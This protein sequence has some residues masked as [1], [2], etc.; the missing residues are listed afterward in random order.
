MP[1]QIRVLV[2]GLNKVIEFPSSTA[3]PDI[4]TAIKGNWSQVEE[5]SGLPMDQASRMSR[6]KH[7]GFDTKTTYYHATKA[8]FPEFMVGG[9][10]ETTAGE[11]YGKGIY[12]SKN[13]DVSSGF[14]SG[15]GSNIM[16]LKT[17]GKFFD[18]TRK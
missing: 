8:D 11:L 15:E 12:T 9:T 13:P 1:G 3:L 6:A 17:G 14:V 18:K 7:L 10:S 4:E 2:K 16:P 5:L